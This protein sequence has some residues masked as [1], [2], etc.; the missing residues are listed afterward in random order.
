MNPIFTNLHSRIHR[1]PS[2]ETA[3][4]KVWVKREDELG[5]G[6][7]GCKKRK[8][9][10]L[11][12]FVIENK[13]TKV[14][15]IGGENSNHVQAFLQ[16]LNENKI[17]SRLFLKK[18]KNPVPKGNSFLLK[19]LANPSSIQYVEPENWSR[20]GEVA[21]EMMEELGEKQYFIVP[22]G[23]SCEQ[24]IQGLST[25][26]ADIEQNEKEHSLIFDHIFIDAGTSLTAAVLAFSNT[27]L[28]RKTQ[29][30][31]V[32]IAG[33]AQLF[34]AQWKICNDFFISNLPTKN[35]VHHL[36][37]SAKSFGSVNATIWTEISKL[38]QKEGLL[39]DPIYTA[40][41]FYTAK[42]VIQNEKLEGN[43]LII[44]SGG[45]TGLMGFGGNKE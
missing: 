38:A 33:N 10:S 4:A 40:K 35:I 24:S 31:V 2:Y 42:Q 27:Q 22:E 17:P 11:L 8:Y 41:L 19:L 44:H 28:A 25:L 7:S 45:G 20:V 9:L 5:F 23:G 30:H 3:A 36:P 37:A 6:I 43:I 16:L 29:I 18:Q 34:E 15:L 13:F 32:H 26:M 12:P 21:K 39:C 1:L 14:A